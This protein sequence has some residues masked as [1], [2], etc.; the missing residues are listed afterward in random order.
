MV[1]FD[2]MIIFFFIIKSISFFSKGLI[3]P[4]VI[5][6][7]GFRKCLKVWTKNSSALASGLYSE[8]ICFV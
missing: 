4:N 2:V 8:L 1:A 3:P 5:L 6:Y 7:E